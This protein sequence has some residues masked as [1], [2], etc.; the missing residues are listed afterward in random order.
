MKYSHDFQ[1]KLHPIIDKICIPLLLIN[2]DDAAPERLRDRVCDYLEQLNKILDPSTETHNHAKAHAWNV[3]TWMVEDYSDIM[4][5]IPA[6]NA[7]HFRFK[8]VIYLI[9]KEF[10]YQDLPAE[11]FDA[12]D[13]NE[14]TYMSDWKV[15]DESVYRQLVNKYNP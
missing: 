1:K 15:H 6:V 11:V 13:V 5:T 7:N 9:A 10:D 3:L 14:K 2:H 4:S 8:H 12:L